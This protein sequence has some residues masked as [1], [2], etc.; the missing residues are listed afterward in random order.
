MKKSKL[1]NFTT[2]DFVSEKELE[3]KL[4]RWDK[5][6]DKY[7]PK[8]KAN[9]LLRVVTTKIQNK[10]GISRLGHLFEYEDEKAYKKRQP[11]FEKIERKEKEHQLI[12]VFA[13]KGI[14]LEE[15]DFRHKEDDQVIT[16]IKIN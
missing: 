6:K 12:K 5:V 3:L 8:L 4:Y 7:I 16:L 11:F 15:Y 2:Q 14:I 13:N 1:I 10:E 9:G